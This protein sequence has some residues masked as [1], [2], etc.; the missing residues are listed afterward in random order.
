MT[1][2]EG[3]FLTDQQLT[4]LYDKSVEV[5]GKRD[6][7]F[8]PLPAMWRD[9]ATAYWDRIRLKYN[10]FMI[11]YRKD[12]NGTPGS[13][14]NGNLM[15]LF[16]NASLHKKT[17]KPPT[18]SYFGNQ[19]LMV[20]SSFIVNVHQNIYF[21]DFYC[22]NLRDHYVTLV[23][24]RPGSVVDKFCQRNLKQINVFHNP[25]LKIVNGKLYVTLGANI[26]VFYTDIVD[27]NR[28]VHERIGRFSPVTFRGVG[29]KEFGIAKNLGCKICNLW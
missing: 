29:S 12:F 9:K 2:S 13:A 7:R 10:G 4:M 20:N 15:G 23:V 3:T 18:F 6:R 28:L 8:A 14:I 24:A 21:V 25:F 19:R 16:F 22:H 26:E 27:V 5:I 11:P 1:S 17:K